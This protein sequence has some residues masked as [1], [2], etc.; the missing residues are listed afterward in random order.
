MKPPIEPKTCQVG[1]TFEER[2]VEVAC[3]WG[4]LDRVPK[5]FLTEETL[6]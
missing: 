3:K 2:K 6:L 5:E 1:P 4:E